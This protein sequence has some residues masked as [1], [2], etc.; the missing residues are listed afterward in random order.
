[1]PT[2]HSRD[3]RVNAWLILAA[4]ATAACCCCPDN[5]ALDER[6]AEE[7]YRMVQIRDRGLTDV[8]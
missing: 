3:A 8:R 4:L 7:R 6:A 1:M 5:A 2:D